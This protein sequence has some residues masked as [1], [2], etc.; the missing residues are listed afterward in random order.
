MVIILNLKIQEAKKEFDDKNYVVALEILNGEKFDEEYFKLVAFLKIGCLRSLKRHDEAL[1][2][3]NSAIEKYPYEDIFWTQKVQCHY[4]NDEKDKALKSLMEVER[5]VDVN[6]KNALVE[7]SELFSLVG[8]YENALKYCNVALSIDENFVDAVRQKAMVASF[9][10]DYDMM[11]DCADRLLQL[12]DKD[13]LKLMVPLMLK[14]FSKRYDDALDI[15]NGVDILDEEYD[16]LLKSAIHN[17]MVEDLNIEIGT[18]QPVEI[19]ID[20]VLGILMDYHYNG[21]ESGEIQG[22]HYFIIKR[23]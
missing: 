18:A 3:I 16:L 14:L 20:D 19:T 11:N 4:F 2:V 15:V 22:V 13:V 9:L 23:E 5:I 10:E 1:D 12:Y 21:V 6:D 8:D 7:V 17:F